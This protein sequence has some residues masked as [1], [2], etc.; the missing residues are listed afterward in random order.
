MSAGY[1]E[2]IDP[3][4]PA[5]SCRVQRPMKRLMGLR[6]V[7]KA[8]LRLA[9]TVL[10]AGLFGSLIVASAPAFG[11][12]EAELDTRLSNS[13]IDTLRSSTSG[14]GGLTSYITLLWGLL[15]GDFGVSQSLNRPVKELLTERLPVSARNL[16][17]GVLAGSAL[18]F[19]AA[20]L[21]IRF[22]AQTLKALI[23]G[24]S[25]SFL[26]IPSA[27][28]ALLF[29][30][31][32]LPGSLALAA[33]VLPRVYRYSSAILSRTVDST[34]VVAAQARGI[35]PFRILLA[36]IVRPAAPQLL[37]VFGMALSIAFPALVPIEAVCDSPGIGQL[38]WKAALARDLPVLVSLVMTSAVIVSLGNAA[39]D[40][41]A[42]AIGRAI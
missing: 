32:G 33:M 5:L 41:S 4:N 9:L 42:D 12:T 23:S 35:A 22:R 11:V 25:A 21:T 7:W 15:R 40:L 37:A 36:Y 14:H 1:K 24:A 38:A 29:L 10:A 28:M 3:I 19:L 2:R 20:G 18:G 8:C 16:A 13:T 27:A 30:L 17:V 6:V 39:A 26:S 31:A 34:Q